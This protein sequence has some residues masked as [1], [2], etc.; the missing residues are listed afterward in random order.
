MIDLTTPLRYVKGI[1]P[2][3]SEALA[4]EGLRTVED[5]LFHLPFRYEDRSRFLPIASLL[6]GLR[7]T[8]RG[9]VVTAALRRTRRRGLSIFEALVEDDSGSI[10]VVFFNQPYLNR[11]LAP[12][13]EVILHGEATPARFGRRG[14]IMQSP[15][16]EVLAREDDEAIHTGRVVPIYPRLPGLSSRAI[17]RI[18]HA[19][20]GELRAS[21]PDPLPPGLAQ[22]RGFP[23]RRAALALAHF[24]PEDTDLAELQ[25]GRSPAHRRLV[26]E[27]FFFL[28]LGFALA[29]QRL[30]SLPEEPGLRVDDP[31]R[32]RLRA[33]LPFRL[34]AA[35][36]RVLKEIAF[37]QMSP[38]PM[39]RL[40]QGDVGC[41]KTV[42]ALLASLLAVENGHQA[43]F[44]APTEILAEQHHRS[45]RRLLEGRGYPIA[46]LTAG[47]KG[48]ARRQV[49]QGL[50]AGTIPILVGTHALLEEEVRFRS[51][52]LAVID[53]QHRFGVAQ[54]ARLRG[55]GKRTD[56]L[57]MT[58]TP[59]PRSLAL[60]VYGDLTLSVIDELPP[61]RRPVKTVLRDERARP[62]VYRFL[63][64]QVAQGR[65]AYVVYPL[66][67]ESRDSELK[68]AVAMAGRLAREVFPDLR[69]GL[70]H[71]RLRPEEREAVMG[72]FAAGT[73]PVLV[74]TT[75]I[76]VGIDVPNATVM[77]IEQ[78]ERFGLSQLHQLR[79]RVGRGSSE[80][81]CILMP[82]TRGTEESL[83]RLQIMCET[84]DGFIIARRDLEMRGP[85]EFLGT[86]QSGIPDLRVGDILR[87]LDILEDA[88][89]EAFDLA[90]RLATIPQR[91]DLVRHMERRW[92]GRLGMVQVG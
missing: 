39:S 41:G 43:A 55:K 40:L 45:F 23:P 64:E 47:V 85:G 52:R 91:G 61:G 81:Y 24:P 79:G 92:G 68:A 44:M 63:R 77:V 90:A 82:G 10:R 38:R 67:E 12:G 53:E 75:V 21:L 66:V 37:D 1:G 78:A 83:R 5:L 22:A 76:E 73:I 6:P 19:A 54:R 51:L 14:L 3:R 42:I 87:D 9:R 60:T 17:R 56:V 8:V 84:N 25:A 65:Q 89:R 34:T 15:Q 30:E 88:R 62:G 48:A 32:E 35:Q 72:D 27:E 11:L 16:Y 46:L 20:L 86:R 4:T 28:Q 70:L 2:R 57:V 69:V 18:V 33:V 31:V 59:I 49:L 7:G 80:S 36:R 13:R 26:F 29:R 71:G 58:A 74:A 50:R